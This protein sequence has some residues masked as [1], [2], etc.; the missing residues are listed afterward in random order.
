MVK[1]L[2]DVSPNLSFQHV[3]T[4]SALGKIAKDNNDWDFNK[5]QVGDW[6]EQMSRRVRTLCR[7]VA[8]IKWRKQKP[9]WFL[10]VFGTQARHM[11][12]PIWL[13]ACFYVFMI[14]TSLLVM[15]WYVSDFEA[16]SVAATQPHGAAVVTAAPASSTARAPIGAATAGCD[17]VEY[18]YGYD[19]EAEAQRP[20]LMCNN[21]RNNSSRTLA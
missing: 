1:A 6:Q 10:N 2:M 20:M 5:E 16:C 15:W 4:K 9:A 13:R 18:D 8:Q 7:H 19:D 14:L 11:Q 21:T 12:V 17:K 3:A